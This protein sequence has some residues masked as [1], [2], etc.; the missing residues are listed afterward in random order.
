MAL[1]DIKS[2][3][4]RRGLHRRRPCRGAAPARGRRQRSG[5]VVARTGR[6]PRRRPAGLPPAYETSMRLL[7]DPEIDAVHIASPNHLHAEQ[8]RAVL[9][10]GK[11]VICEKPLALDSAGDRRPGR[12]RAE[13]PGWSTR[14]ASTS[15][16]IRCAIR[17][18][19]WCR[20]ARSGRRDSSP[21]AT[22]R[23]GCCSTPIGT[24]VWFREQAGELRSVADIG[25]HWL[26]LSRFITGPQGGGGD[27]RAPHLRAGPT[28]PRRTGRDIRPTADEREPAT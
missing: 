22:C 13:A 17:C 2:G 21:A 5:G 19:R 10:A 7:A 1:S 18:G 14:S 8:V 16:S 26:D 15:A 4:R 24:G 27:G 9:A 3:R 6:G 25:S 20:R 23:T 12:A 11:H 28:P